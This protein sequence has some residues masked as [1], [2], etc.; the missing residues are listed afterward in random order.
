MVTRIVLDPKRTTRILF[1]TLA[2]L[3][4]LSVFVA[5]GHLVLHWRMQSLTI[6]LDLDREANLPTLFNVLLFYL[7]AALFLLHG[8]EASVETA[9]GWKTMAW[10]FLFLGV[11]EGAQVHEKFVQVTKRVFANTFGDQLGGWFNYAWVIPYALALVLLA[12]Y[13]LRWFLRLPAPM[14]NRLLMGGIIYV[15]GAL[16]LEMAGG[17]LM[18]SLPPTNPADYPWLF[19]DG[20]I[21]MAGYEVDVHPGIIALYTVEETCEMAGLILCIRALLLEFQAK[22]RQ[23]QLS[24]SELD[25]GTPAA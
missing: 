7:G 14:R 4:A 22:R 16:F 15:F 17:K 12:A 8:R 24:V 19:P 13:L 2:I 25:A 3:V 20:T 5:F 6:L 18:D 1:I 10:A 11:D 23:V 21:L 9:G